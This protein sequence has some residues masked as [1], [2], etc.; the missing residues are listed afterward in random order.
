MSVMDCGAPEAESSGAPRWESRSVRGESAGNHDGAVHD[1]LADDLELR[2]QLVG[3][4]LR[5]ALFAVG[6]A[7]VAPPHQWVSGSETMS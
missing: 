3:N 2:L 1:L 6:E 5:H 4:L 7:D